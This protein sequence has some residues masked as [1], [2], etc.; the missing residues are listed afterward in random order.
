MNEPRLKISPRHHFFSGA[1]VQHSA[2][3][4]V[5][6]FVEGKFHQQDGANDVASGRHQRQQRKYG[7]F[8]DIGLFRIGFE[9]S[10]LQCHT[11]DKGGNRAGDFSHQIPHGKVSAFLALTR[12]VLVIVNDI[13]L[14]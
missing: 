3:L 9:A 5:L 12:Q 14:N 2:N 4:L 11:N 10:H 8:G 7:P 13:S 1:L 6:F